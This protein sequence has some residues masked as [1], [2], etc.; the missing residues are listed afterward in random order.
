[1]TMNAIRWSDINIYHNFSKKY[2][3]KC[4]FVDLGKYK[5]AFDTKNVY[6]NK[7]FNCCKDNSIMN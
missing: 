5:N 2:V 3:F 6:K 4:I 7:C 1:M